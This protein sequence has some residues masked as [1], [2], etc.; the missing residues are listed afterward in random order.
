[1]TGLDTTR[2][3]RPRL[4]AATAMALCFLSIVAVAAPKVDPEA[5]KV[6]RAMAKYV[7]GLQAFSFSLDLDNEIL[8]TAGQKLQLS[9]SSKIAVERPNKL[10]I[11]RQGTLADSELFF[12]G[13]AV[14]LFSKEKNFY[15]Q[16]QSPG[17]IDDAINAVRSQTEIDAAGADLLYADPYPGLTTDLVSGQYLGRSFVHG[18]ECHHLAFRADKVDWQIWVRDGDAPVPMKYVITTKWVTGA[19]QYS[20]RFRDWDTKSKAQPERFKF[21][22]PAGAKLL[23][24]ISADAIGELFAEEEK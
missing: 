4:L 10:Y 17:T 14:T 3:G 6:L 18:V 8:D 5:D 7:G 24:A 20:I 1:M 23:K 12:D 11:Y 22:A 9:S 21:T 13:K 19:P 2:G 16:L 15:F